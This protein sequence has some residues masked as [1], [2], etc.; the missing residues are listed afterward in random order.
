MQNVG[1]LKGNRRQTNTFENIGINQQIHSKN[2]E[3]TRGEPRFYDQ[4][5]RWTLVT[6]QWVV[7]LWQL[8]LFPGVR[9][10]LLSVEPVADQG[11][12]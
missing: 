3:G 12:L 5:Q 8:K 4:F 7:E 2:P 1:K 9:D 6:A 11:C 10:T